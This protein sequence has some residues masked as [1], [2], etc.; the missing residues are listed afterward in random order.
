[1][2]YQPPGT[3]RVLRL[4]AITS[5]RRLARVAK[6]QK[7]KRAQQSGAPVDARKRTATRRKG[8]DGLLWLMA[9]M[10]P[11]FLLQGLMMATQATRSLAAS[12]EQFD[13]AMAGV[14]KLDSS[15]QLVMPRNLREAIRYSSDLDEGELLTLLDQFEVDEHHRPTRTQIVEF[16][17]EHGPLKFASDYRPV[18]VVLLMPAVEWQSDEAR[19]L[20]VNGGAVLLAMIVLMVI[21]VGLG[22]ANAT[23]SGGEWTQ[24]WLMSFPVATRS[25]VLARLLEYAFVQ[26][27]PWLVLWPLS[28]QLLRA[29]DQPGALWLSLL[30]TL[31]VLLV[32][33]ALRLW[34]ETTL[35][36]RLSLHALKNVQG[37]CTI[38]S[39]LLMAAV[40]GVCL[41]PTM[42]AS[43]VSICGSLPAAFVLL[44]GACLLAPATYAWLGYLLGPLLSIAIVLL[45]WRSTSLQLRGGVMRTGGVDAGKRGKSRG[46]Q[47]HAKRLGVV[48]KD[49]LQLRRDRSFMVQTLLVPLFMVGIQ[50]IANPALGKLEIGGKALAMLAYFVALYGCLGGGLQVLRGEGRAL[51]MLYSLP[52]SIANALRRKARLWATI[53]LALSV[54]T[55][56]VVAWG[57]SIELFDAARH[58]LVMMVGVWSVAHIAAGIGILGVNPTAD[59]VPR[60]MKQRYVALY[61]FL[62]FTFFAVLAN[63]ELLSQLAGTVIF[64]TMAYA[65]W[66][67]ACDRL[68]WLLDPVDEVRDRVNLMDGASAVFVFYLLQLVALVVARLMAKGPPSQITIA[69]A[70]TVAGVTTVLLFLLRLQARGVALSALLG[71][72]GKAR[73]VRFTCLAAVALGLALGLMGLGYLQLAVRWGWYVPEPASGSRVAL[74]L[75]ACVAAPLVEELLFRGLVLTGLLRSVRWPLAVVWSSALFAVVHPHI[76]WPPVFVL[77]V[78]AALLFRRSGYLPAAMLLHASYNYVVVAYQ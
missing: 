48:G 61:F 26:F 59:Y 20:F 22:G 33:G 66:Q 57:R 13:P 69:I 42:P 71:L 74:L 19:S 15:R 24:A 14:M 11:L 21:A 34:L 32:T 29:L 7:H 39:L 47:Q 68:P 9:L 67:R 44:P 41:S 12:V 77:G 78:T 76:A 25:L 55:F 60:Q 1:M 2:S 51:W 4:L 36:L 10:L 43:F 50:A 38:L 28:Y 73:D 65:F 18:H 3:L 35:R 49:L 40:F 58:L 30:A 52:I 45:A 62:G 6:I 46:W 27:F 37:A 63:D 53:S 56:V 5:L 17:R 16:W 72:D 31:L 54:V 70:F 64:A 23:L 8:G 75:L